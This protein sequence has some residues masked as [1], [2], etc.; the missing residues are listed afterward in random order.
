[1]YFWTRIRKNRARYSSSRGLSED[2]IP[3]ILQE[4]VVLQKD[5]SQACNDLLELA[6]LKRYFDRLATPV[7]KQHFQSHLRKYVSM[8][9]TDCP[10]EITTTNRYEI[11]QYEASVSARKPIKKNEEIKYLTGIQVAIT[12]E[13]EVTLDLTRTDFSIVMSSRKKTPSLFL[14][15]ARFAN[16]DCNANARLSTTGSHGMQV[17]AVRDIE[18]GEEITV[19]Y[20]ADYFGED[21]CECLC[22]TCE[23]LRRNGWGPIENSDDEDDE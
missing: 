14:G 19:T 16:H 21:N 11:S 15:P 23:R 9:M 17:V 12:K 22:A 2:T 18:L 13:E 3:P 20:G 4:Q 1:M 5:V 6:G 10:F 7:E 8:Y